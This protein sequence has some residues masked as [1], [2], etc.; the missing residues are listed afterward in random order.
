ML[1]TLRESERIGSMR[2]SAN[3]WTEGALEARK[4]IERA[5][6]GNWS[7]LSLA[8]LNLKSLPREI[9]QLSNLTILDISE[10][11]LRSL[12]PEI[13][14]LGELR[15]LHAYGNELRLLP[16]EIRY[17]TS[18]ELLDVSHNE[19]R[20]LPSEV[21]ELKS[22]K[23]LSVG[24]NHL[25]SL[26]PEVGRLSAL[27]TLDI[28]H[29][30]FGELPTAL[31]LLSNLRTFRAFGNSFA[32]AVS[33]LITTDLDAV[34]AYLTASLAQTKVTTNEVKLVFVGV[35]EVGKTCLLH[36][37]QNKVPK[38]QNPTTEGFEV[39]REAFFL[40]HPEEPERKLQFNC[41]DF[42]GQREYR[43]AHQ[44]FFS[45]DSLYLVLWNERKG[46]AQCELEQWLT[47]IKLR[48]GRSAR[49]IVVATHAKATGRSIA[50][51]RS[52]LEKKFGEVI[53]GF[54]E[55]DTFYPDDNA[56]PELRHGVSDLRALLA[57]E[58][59]ALVAKQ[60]P[61]PVNWIG[62][63]N[64]VAQIA[65]SGTEDPRQWITYEEFGQTA[66][67]NGVTGDAARTLAY[68]ADVQ[69]HWMFYHRPDWQSD[70]NE[71]EALSSI[72]ILDPEA[73][74]KAIGYVI[75]DREV[76]KKSGVLQFSELGRVWSP[77]RTHFPQEK[78][79]L[80]VQ[81]MERHE[82]VYRIPEQDAL[83]VAERVRDDLPPDLPWSADAPPAAGATLELVCQF[84][85]LLPPGLIPLLTVRTHR[86]RANDN[87]HWKRGTFLRHPTDGTAL[88]QLRDDIRELRVIVNAAYPSSLLNW[89]HTEFE[90]LAS[91]V[92]PGLVR[93]AIDGYEMRV[94]CVTPN[95][96]GSIELGALRDAIAQNQ[97]KYPCET[98]RKWLDVNK[99]LHGFDTPGFDLAEQIS[100]VSDKVDA[101]AFW[102]WRAAGHSAEARQVIEGF[103]SKWD[104]LLE[105]IDDLPTQI[106]DELRSRCSE[107]YYAIG[108]LLTDE[109]KAGPA[110]ISLQYMGDDLAHHHY[111]ARLWCEEPDCPHPIPDADGGALD[112]SVSKKWAQNAASTITWMVKILKVA[113]PVGG[114]VLSEA[115]SDLLSDAVK[116]TIKVADKCAAALPT[117]SLDPIEG[118]ERDRFMEFARANGFGPWTEPTD[119]TPIHQV[120]HQKRPDRPFAPL[121][122]G[123][124]Q[125]G[126]IWWL[127]REH[128]DQRF[129]PP[130]DLKL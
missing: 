54:V 39:C 3:R 56:P 36:V 82:I 123:I 58:A 78:F 107:L 31:G 8:R 34:R 129:P 102:S 113:I 37:L 7:R 94:P 9:G 26:P 89:I 90:S 75:T 127:C 84:R 92:W 15:E 71:Q 122:R 59:A 11:Y 79:R 27:E 18:L 125:S 77:G 109:R 13:E 98:C 88:L 48:V 81:L 111:Q 100:R 60:L 105:E 1:T 83:L 73:L 99:L 93:G 72:L 101:S 85:G 24:G 95:C 124:T 22:L 97:P 30:Q 6:A 20:A 120:F 32:P 74:G 40:P 17:L 110:L 117:G 55:V 116:S 57:R 49:V 29:N 66:S 112:F 91:K 10:N 130:P 62:V 12:P 63:R 51:D 44:F 42:G 23:A 80:L 106:S 119:L 50:L 104:S 86:Y 65:Q 103:L 47:Q 69:G 33:D 108:R 96:H 76:A 114:A 52:D 14:Y 43:V 19:L 70:T 121:R 115:A 126:Q 16:S 41:W 2:S 118:R 38:R 68:L 87:C 45:P 128:Y 28:S 25:A 46:A 67:K 4:R 61:W 64:T 53:A 5:A 35:G 21:A